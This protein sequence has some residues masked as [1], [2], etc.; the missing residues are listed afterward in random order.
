MLK[1]ACAAAAAIPVTLEYL[2]TA[3]IPPA[4]VQ[5]IVIVG[6]RGQ[7]GRALMDALADRALLALDFPETDITRPAV[8]DEIVAFQPELVINAAAWTD[9]DGAEDN[10]DRCYAV[11]VTGVQHLALACQRSGAALLHI[12]T[13]EVFPGAAGR[14]YREWDA[15]AAHN[16]VY[17]RSKEAAEK[18][19]ISL[20]A[21]R[22]Y[23]VRTAWLYNNGGN[24]FNVKI[25]AVADRHGSLRVVDDEFGNPTYAPDLAAAIVQLVD[26]QRHGIY[27][28]TNSGHC[29]RY[30]WAVESLRLAG[31]DVPVTPIASS[32]WQ[33]RTTPPLHAILLNT[34]GA[35][36]GIILRPWREAL[37]AYYENEA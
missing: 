18:V 37:A 2:V 30:E 25:A 34:T 11:N 33:R 3:S 13:N 4:P 28:F 9:V 36:Q 21:G 23:I 31:R 1:C 24:N 16:G 8:I 17:A 15:T 22:F 14:F 35:A 27:H 12:S 7:L 10:A 20:L 6:F 29:T 5:R 32:E 19:V 26:S